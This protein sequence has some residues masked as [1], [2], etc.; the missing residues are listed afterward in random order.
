ML[1][2]F[3]IALLCF[4]TTT[5][6]LATENALGADIAASGWSLVLAGMV[7]L[8]TGSLLTRGHRPLVMGTVVG[9]TLRGARKLLA[10]DR[11]TVNP[12]RALTAR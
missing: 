4:G 10:V 7:S 11:R 5:V 6:V 9:L 12:T 3:G 1:L 2:I 8:V